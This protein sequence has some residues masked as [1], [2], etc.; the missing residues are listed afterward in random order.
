MSN[1]FTIYIAD[2]AA[3]LTTYGAG[4]LLRVQSSAT[5]LGVYADITAPTQAIVS[6]ETNYG[7]YDPDGIASDF[8]KWR[9]EAS[10]GDPAGAY[11]DPFQPMP[12]ATV[13]ARSPLIPGAKSS[14]S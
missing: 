2:S 9:A 10:D 7:W 8:Y 1:V 5:E 11:S 4:A 6:G 12:M 3:L 13:Y 14:H